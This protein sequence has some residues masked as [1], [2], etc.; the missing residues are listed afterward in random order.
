MTALRDLEL[1]P[2]GEGDGVATVY[3][4]NVDLT[5]ATIGSTDATLTCH[6]CSGAVTGNTAIGRVIQ[7]Y[8]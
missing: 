8:G 6:V 7:L 2:I 4:G 5:G 1:P 3:Y